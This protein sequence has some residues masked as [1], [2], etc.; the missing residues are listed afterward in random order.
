MV[1][2]QSFMLSYKLAVCRLQLHIQQTDM[3]MVTHISSNSR[4]ENKCLYISK[5][6]DQRMRFVQLN[7]FKMPF[8]FLCSQTSPPP[9]EHG[10]PQGQSDRLS[11]MSRTRCQWCKYE[12]SFYASV[13]LLHLEQMSA[14]R[15]GWADKILA[16]TKPVLGHSTRIQHPFHQRIH[17]ISF[18]KSIKV[19]TST[20]YE[21]GQRWMY[22]QRD[23]LTHGIKW[24][25]VKVNI[26]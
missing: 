25:P 15:Q 24:N 9:W 5:N 17:S 7:L 20:H 6:V 26:F 12:P 18:I 21:S 22:I 13:H 1:V 8:I 16:V 14:W 19:C 4:Q 3:I 2:F 11:M 23:W 10:H